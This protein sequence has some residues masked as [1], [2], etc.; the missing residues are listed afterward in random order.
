MKTIW[1]IQGITKDFAGKRIFKIISIIPEIT[2]YIV[3]ASINSEFR[4]VIEEETFK[5]LSFM[6][7][8]GYQ[9]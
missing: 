6:K 3:L 2:F 4:R 5:V 1:Q 9:M 7:F 8:N